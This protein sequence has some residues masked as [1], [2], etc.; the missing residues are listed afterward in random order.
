MIAFSRRIFG[1]L[2]LL[3]AAGCCAEARLPA[4]APT[5]LP[6]LAQLLAERSLLPSLTDC[7]DGLMLVQILSQLGIPAVPLPLDF[8]VEE[9]FPLCLPGIAGEVYLRLADFQHLHQAEWEDCLKLFPPEDWR[10]VVL[11]LRSS[12]G[13]QV[14]VAEFYQ[15]QLLSR[16]LP[17][18]ILIDGD[19]AGTAELLAENLR[20]QGNSLLLGQKSAGIRGSGQELQVAKGLKFRCALQVDG[21]LP[22]PLVPDVELPRRDNQ[23][24]NRLPYRSPI[25]DPWCRHAAGILTVILT[26]TK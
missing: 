17:M 4:L 19:T 23:P 8:E 11:D 1:F 25:N 7:D 6:E 5:A 3:H 22:G 20:Q 9:R 14:E 18:M 21:Q 26:L 15:Q 24:Y 13:F 2:F 10:G 12:Q 16:N